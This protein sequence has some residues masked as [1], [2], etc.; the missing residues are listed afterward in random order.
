LLAGGT[1][2]AV[3]GAVTNLNQIL[4][5]TP[6][7]PLAANTTYTI[8]I[9]GVKDFV[10]NTMVGT[11][12]STFTTGPGVDF[13]APA[14]VS[15]TPANDTPGVPAATKIQIQFSKAMN[16][17]T[18]DQNAGN[19]TLVTTNTLNPVS[20][21]VALS[22]D[23]KTATLTPSSLAGGTQHTVTVFA[24]GLMD[25]SGNGLQAGDDIS[26]FTTQ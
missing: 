8:S 9:V 2:V 3:T 1:Q 17:L 26:N 19:I 11:I 22:T 16:P 4:T 20:F 21:T 14:I 12:T 5:L 18:F 13:T 25:V 6:A 24:G 23:F 15:L 7:D 10:G